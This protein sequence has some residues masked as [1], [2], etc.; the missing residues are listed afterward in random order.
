MKLRMATY[1]SHESSKF[2]LIC[3]HHSPKA[4]IP[5]CPK[6]HSEE[7]V[8]QARLKRFSCGIPEST[9][10]LFEGCNYTFRCRNLWSIKNE[11]Q[12]S[13]IIPSLGHR[14]I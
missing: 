11:K 14:M 3:W 6:I 8:G 2:D 7:T 5:L 13:T 10:T 1:L 12:E 4:D 9:R